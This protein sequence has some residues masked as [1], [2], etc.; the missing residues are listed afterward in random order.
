MVTKYIAV[1]YGPWG[2]QKGDFCQ[3]PIT[4]KFITKSCVIPALLV[5]NLDVQCNR[6]LTKIT[7]LESP[8]SID[9]CY[10]FGFHRQFRLRPKIVKAS[11]VMQ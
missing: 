5:L 10:V 6:I 11:R 4:S 8:G 7:F 9:Y 1:I 2:F 3:D